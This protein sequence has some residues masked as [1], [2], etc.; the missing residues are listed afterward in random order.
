MA[1]VGNAPDEYFLAV[2][3]T[4]GNRWAEFLNPDVVRT[5]FVTLG[6]FMVAYEMLIQ[7]ITRRPREFFA[8]SWTAEK[9]WLLSDSYCE[10]VL[11]LDPKG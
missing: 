11:A 5:K 6:L 1:V 7:A 10:S 2:D 3:E 4:I 8:D 9:E